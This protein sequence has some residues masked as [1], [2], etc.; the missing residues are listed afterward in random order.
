MTVI[1]GPSTVATTDV[2]AH[3]PNT[4][5]HGVNE[6][7]FQTLWSGDRD[8]NESIEA[9][10]NR[11]ALEE[12]ANGTD[13][14]L[15]RPPAAVERWNRGD[16]REFPATDIDRSIH[17]SNASLEDGLLIKDAYVEFFAIQPSTRAR[18]SPED[19]LLYV[20]VNG[21]VLGVV[22]Y[23][24][25]L[26][27]E[28]D[29]D[30]PPI[31]RSLVSARIVETHLLVDGE[32]EST[33]TGNHTPSLAFSALDAY[34][35]DRHTLTLVAEIEVTIAGGATAE[36]LAVERLTVTDSI[37]VVE[38][39][40]GLSG[41]VGAYPDGDL[42]LVVYKDRPWLGYSLPGGDV[43]GVWR[44]YSARD[45]QW[46][47]LVTSTESGAT[48]RH[49]SLHPLQVNAYPIEPGPTASPR[50][51]VRILDVDG[52]RT[53]PPTLPSVV[54]LDVL[55]EPYTASYGIATRTETTDHDLST[56][57]AWGL[58]RGESAVAKES[59]FADIPI[60]RTN[61]TLA[62][63]N[64]TKESVTV[65]VR[66][67]NAETGAPID[68]SE[69]Q[70]SI[71]LEGERVNTGANGTVTQ[72]VPRGAGSLSAR[73]RPQPWWYE[74]PGYVP[75]SDVV[76]VRGTVLRT[77]STLFRIGVPVSL[78]LAGVFLID[79]FTGWNLWPPWR[80]L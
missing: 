3:P 5:D 28:V 64:V 56:V 68:T 74:E 14:P 47:T 67:T 80:G 71:V 75:A 59:H 79:R 26:T 57:T 33:A 63:L 10:E 61:L 70:G 54:H 8:P 62:V 12:L 45:A 40:L 24:V 77:V 19:Q 42:G 37:E 78:F 31:D 48:E 6:T 49:S 13:V 38:Y 34:A 39:D 9:A 25:D 27:P 43:H 15:N 29:V 17:P 20:P 32:V 22:D 35:G 66:L 44:F 16:H 51:T 58:V 7:T 72:T 50:G 55:A 2:A 53:T 65:R 60:H 23:R 30:G 4:T 52:N 36:S 1:A 41:V 18:I 21:T 46:D 11:S 69:R 73:Y 76:H